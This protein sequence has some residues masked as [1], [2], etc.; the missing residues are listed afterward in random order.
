MIYPEETSG[1][2]RNG[3]TRIHTESGIKF[4]MLTTPGM[5]VFYG[6]VGVNYPD[7]PATTILA[8]GGGG[9]F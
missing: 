2:G 9:I 3:V 5:L 4:S 6:V 7:R 8:G 1:D